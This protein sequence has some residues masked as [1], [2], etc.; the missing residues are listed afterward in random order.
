[1]KIPEGYLKKKSHTIP[2]GYEACEFEGY[3]KPIPEQLEVL[4]K[5]LQGVTEQKYSLREAAKLISQET[6]R[7]IS[8][9]AVKNYIDSDPS[10]EEQHKKKLAKR[11]AKIAKAKKA[12][13]VKERKV[14]AQEQVIKKATEQSTSHIVT[15]EELKE[16]PVDVQEQLRDAKVV[17][18]ANEGPQT[19]FLAADEKDVLYGGA[20][21]GGKSYAM[22]VDPLRYAHKKAHRALILR[23]SMPELREMID[24]SRELYPQAFPGAKFREVEKLWNF[25]SG[26]KI[27]FGFLERD[28]DVY[29]YQGQAY[30]WIGFDEITHL[31]TEFSWNYLASRLRTTDPEI[32]TYLRCTANPGGSGAHWVKKRY[33]EPSESNKSFLGEDG[34]TRKFIPA[35]LQ[36]NPYLAKDGV[37][38]QMLKSLPP[39]QRRQLLEGN[40]EVAEGAAFVEFDPTK[41]IVTPF[42]IPVHWERVKGVDYGYAAESCCLWGAIDINDG[43][44]IIYRE[45][46]R[47]GLTGEELGSI[48]GNMEL[49]DPFSVPGVLDTAAWARTGTTGPTVGEA[50]IKAGH[51]LRRADKNRIQGKIQI[52]EFLKVKENGRPRLQIF[53]SCPNL[54]RE[55]QSI[56]LSKTNPEDVDTNA[57]DHAYDALRY[58]IMSRPRVD[59]PLERI[60]G[61]KR[62]MHQPAD[63]T[64]GY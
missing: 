36:D 26:A 5:Y 13:Y 47:K 10:L 53:N 32:K 2:F 1:M 62:Q 50:L 37:Y 35:K 55:L 34:L 15:D 11:K 18:S 58:L 30:S 54:I 24:K 45:L 46:Y 48:I 38:E 43:T 60:R 41:H 14:K 49:E 42:Q 16:V 21:G 3:I 59:S 17:F 22:L 25:P 27:E 39:I 19:D 6:G 31:P 44:L 7:N 23:R 56:P 64:F 12:L 40:W 33:I 4:H 63:S 51:K 8:H 28:A 20:A 9:V 57:S 61:L 29:R 52:H